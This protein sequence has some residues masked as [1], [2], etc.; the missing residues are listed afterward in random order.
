MELLNL[1]SFNK[2]I[3]EE[4]AVKA[5]VSP[6]N[7]YFDEYFLDAFD[8]NGH[9]IKLKTVG[10]GIHAPIKVYIDDN[11]WELFKGENKARKATANFIDSGEYGKT[12]QRAVQ[13]QNLAA[14]VQQQPA[15]KT[16]EGIKDWFSKSSADGKKGW[17]QVGGKYDGKPCARQPGQTT[18]PK[19]TSSSKRSSMSKKEKE[20][21]FRRKNQQDPNQPQKTGAAK[22]TMVK[23]DVK[24]ESVMNEFA[25]FA[26]LNTE[27]LEAIREASMKNT[28]SLIKLENGDVVKVSPDEARVLMMVH[29]ELNT[30][31]RHTF[32][33]LLQSKRTYNKLLYF[34]KN[35]LGI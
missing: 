11:P 31:N 15:Q 9:S 33:K 6:S 13:Q 27:I 23:T 35:E 26:S 28:T 22:P 14:K 5:G 19:C 21:A 34:V 10:S 25:M 30:R 1:K 32:E 4:D 18:T 24:K 8:Y 17:V 20:S 16:N 7:K 2:Y 3:V 12:V 29:D